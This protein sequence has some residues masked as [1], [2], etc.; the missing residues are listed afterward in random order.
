MFCMKINKITS[1]ILFF[2][3]LGLVL[4]PSKSFTS[5]AYSFIVF[6]GNI[7]QISDEY[8]RNIDKEIGQ[9]TKYSGRKI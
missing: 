7:Y 8:V 6:D 4:F 3:L 1:S 2:I 9:V 5:W